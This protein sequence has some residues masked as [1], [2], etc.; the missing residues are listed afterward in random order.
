MATFDYR[1][2]KDSIKHGSKFD[3]IPYV[4]IDESTVSIGKTYWSGSGTVDGLKVNF[5]YLGQNMN[6]NKFVIKK[7]EIAG[8]GYGSVV[9][10][11]LNWS[12][13]DFST[14]TTSEM[15]K[16]TFKGNDRISGSRQAD[17]IYGEAGSDKIYGKGGYDKLIGGSGNDRLYGGS[18]NDVLIGGSGKNYLSGQGGRDTF[19][20]VRGQGYDIIKD[21][22]DGEDRIQLGNGASGLKLSTRGDDTLIYQRGDLL[23]I[24]EDSA[25]DLQR[26]GN[27]LV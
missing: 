19:K 15:L 21:F 8:N 4:D 24:V 27:F 12:Y 23:A 25:G 13:K 3:A 17:I 22:T 16:K 26:N 11:G 6:S 5:R 2:W 9:F 20:V 10:S 14:L 1:R 7:T 18:G